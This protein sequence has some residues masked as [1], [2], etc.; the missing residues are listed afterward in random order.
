MGFITPPDQNCFSKTDPGPHPQ[1]GTF[2]FSFEIVGDNAIKK[3]FCS[4]RR[5]PEWNG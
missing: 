5:F 3:W 4:L 2:E 1:R